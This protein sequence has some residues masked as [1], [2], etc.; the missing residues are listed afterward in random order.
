M[1]QN[2]IQNKKTSRVT[3]YDW[4]RLIATIYV[5]IGHSA[6]LNIQTAY[7]GVAYE[8]PSVV[9]SSVPLLHFVIQKITTWIYS[10]H[11]PLFFMLSGAVL[12]LKPIGNFGSLVKSK[13]QRLLVPY[14][15]YG[16]LFT[17][18]VKRFS[19]FYDNASWIQAMK[20]F[21]YGAEESHL[22]FLPAL[23]WC[24]IA[25]VL[26]YKLLEKFR[27]NKSFFLLLIS[28]ICQIVCSRI[29][30]DIF[31]L[32]RGLRYIFYFALGYV[33]E[34]IRQKNIRWSPKRNVLLCLVLLLIEVLHYKYRFL[35]GIAMSLVGSALALALADICDQVFRKAT[36]RNWWKI[37]MR[38][39]FYVYIFHD[40]LEYVVLRIFMNGTLLASAFGCV[41]YA[42]LR[43]IGVFLISI[44]LSEAIYR[45]PKKSVLRFL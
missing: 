30:Y 17:L 44:L 2:L 40:P 35:N 22:W 20:A 9:H 7:G 33:F 27:I 36:Q 15:I 11:M 14:Y 4:L 42:F 38:S 21:L 1:S 13:A 26:L 45:L 29:P 5:V 18:P 37:L 34:T 19:N 3:L 16:L 6:Y 28:G 32:I 41:S 31:N 12:A 10:F 43:T 24:M 25:F 8:L 39:M 23:F